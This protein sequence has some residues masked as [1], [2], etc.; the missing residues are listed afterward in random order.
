MKYKGTVEPADND[1]YFGVVTM[2]DGDQST[3]LHRAKFATRARAETWVKN[4][5]KYHKGGGQPR[6]KERLS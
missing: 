4:L 3:V 5:V 6:P 1:R 2:T